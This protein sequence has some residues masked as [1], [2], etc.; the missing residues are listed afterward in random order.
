[1]HNILFYIFK[2]QVTLHI[3]TTILK[4]GLLSPSQLLLVSVDAP[5]IDS[6]KSESVRSRRALDRMIAKSSSLLIQKI[7]QNHSCGLPRWPF[8]REAVLLP[9][10]RCSTVLLQAPEMQA[11]I[12]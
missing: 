4:G 11:V 9:Q 12:I 10:L 7:A 8:Q 2:F 1:M 5:L 6:Q 3:A